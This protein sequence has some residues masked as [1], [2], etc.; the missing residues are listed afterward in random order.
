MKNMDP[1]FEEAAKLA[2]LNQQIS[3][4]FIQRKLQLGFA[5]AGRVMDQLESAGV[6]GPQSGAKSREVLVPDLATLQSILDA[7]CK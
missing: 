6:V 2:V 4:S 5:R 7:Y 3:T 1:M